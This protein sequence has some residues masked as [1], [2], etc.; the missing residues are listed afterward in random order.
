MKDIICKLLFPSLALVILG[1]A[2]RSQT[3]DPEQ[4]KPRDEEI[5]T[6]TKQGDV[7]A[8]YSLGYMNSKG[9]GVS[10]DYVQAHTWLN[11]AV[12]GKDPWWLP[13]ITP[14]QKSLWARVFSKKS[15]CRGKRSYI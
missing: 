15:Y 2:G 5:L 8:Q 1:L 14:E 13:T 12:S 10:Q 6:R 9:A 11:L 7:K 4:R 3:A